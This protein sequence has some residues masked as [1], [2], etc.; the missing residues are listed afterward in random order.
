MVIQ[1]P[2]LTFSDVSYWPLMMDCGVGAELFIE[3]WR[4]V[5]LECGPFLTTASF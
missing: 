2:V 3:G 5:I 4:N 1:R